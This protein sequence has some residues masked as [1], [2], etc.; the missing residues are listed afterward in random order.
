MA[1]VLHPFVE[2]VGE[3]ITMQ[4]TIEDLQAYAKKS[5]QNPNLQDIS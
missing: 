4:Y 1:E 3:A 2:I 5:G